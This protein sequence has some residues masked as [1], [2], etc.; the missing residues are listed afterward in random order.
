MKYIA[1][2]TPPPG[3]SVLHGTGRSQAATMVLEPQQASG[4][5]DNELAGSDQ[6]LF[7]LS[8]QG[9]AVIGGD[10]TVDLGPGA[11]LL[12]EAGETHE[13]NNTGDRP[14]ETLH[15]FAPPEY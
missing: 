10:E 11:L 12:I 1:R 3:F 15:I 7:V 13:I 4:G 14:L 9:R 2:I 5:P 8:G 6:W